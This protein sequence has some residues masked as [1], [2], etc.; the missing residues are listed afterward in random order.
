MSVHVKET[1]KEDDMIQIVCKVVMSHSD[2]GPVDIYWT[3][4]GLQTHQ[5]HKDDF[6]VLV[7]D[8]FSVEEVQM[9]TVVVSTLMVGDLDSD[10]AGLYQCVVGQVLAILSRFFMFFVYYRC[11]QKLWSVLIHLKTQLLFIHHTIIMRTITM[12]VLVH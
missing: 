10:D 4:P 7:T 12:A 6:T 8:K 5:L 2:L 1:Y 9:D 11:L 3:V